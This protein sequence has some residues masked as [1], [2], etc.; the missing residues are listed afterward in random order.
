ML[1]PVVMVK[2]AWDDHNRANRYHSVDSAKNLLNSCAKNAILFTGGDNDT[3]PLW[4]A[5]EVEGFR[6]DVRV[7]NLSLMQTDWYTEQMKM[8]AYKS[9]PLPIKFREDQILMYA[10]NTDQVLFSGLLS[11]ANMNAGE[12]VMKKIIELRMK[13]MPNE[14]KTSAKA[15]VSSISALLAMVTADPANQAALNKSKNKAPFFKGLYI[16]TSYQLNRAY[17]FHSNTP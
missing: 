1:V 8:R 6:T 11:L 16:I 4:Y 5:Q 10:G 15:N 3:F 17:S 2:G 14:M 9:D 7:C 12:D 13:Q